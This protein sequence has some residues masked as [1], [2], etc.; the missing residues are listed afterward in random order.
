MRRLTAALLLS[1]LLLAVAGCEAT[2]TAD[3]LSPSVAGP[4]PG[5]NITAPKTVAPSSARVA[6]DQQPLTL[7][8]ENASSNG[9]RPLTYTFELAT[10]AGFTNKVLSR[11]SVSPGSDGRTSLKLPDPLASGRT[12]YWRARAQDGA[13]TGPYS[14]AANFDVFTPTA[15]DQPIPVMPINNVKIENLRPRFMVTNAARSGPVGAISYVFE[16]SDT[17][18]F[19]NKLAIWTVPEQPNQ[20]AF[21]APQ[22]LQYG[23]QYFWHARAFDGATTGSW[24]A[25]QVFQTP[26]VT[27]DAPQ[28]V[29][30]ASGATVDNLH[31]RF[32]WTNASRTGSVGPVSYTLELSESDTFATRLA[33][34]AVGEQPNQTTLDPPQDLSYGK[35]Y[36]WHVRAFSQ[37]A[38][39]P[40]S[41]TLAFQTQTL[42]LAQAQLV[43]PASGVTLDSL[44]PTFLWNNAP[45]SG[46]VGPV[47]YTLELSDT[48]AFANKLAVWA[49]GEQPNQ[50][51][52]VAPQ[53]LAYSKQY[54]W[55][56]RAFSPLATGAWSAAQAFHT[57]EPPPP[58]APP[59]PPGGGGNPPAPCGPPYPNTPL[60][61]VQCQRSNYGQSMSSTDLV[62]LMTAI[63]RDLNAAGVSGGPF[64]ILRK[65]SGSQCNGYS[66][67]IICAGQGNSQQ[68]WDV[69]SDVGNTNRPTWN[70]P[71]TVPN[72]RVDVCEIQ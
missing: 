3:P 68:Q 55:H 59:P 10:D 20:T 61:I 66:C 48:D 32:F 7:V 35:Q 27:I 46:S 14:A 49:V 8:V 19:A 26:S 60:G 25:T 11:D 69:L 17:D 15:I 65:T 23:K 28:L 34:W 9:P 39:G 67:D 13:N 70:G 16:L 2:K 72:I 37:L 45:R 44:H 50:T 40:W 12:Y 56:V 33:V 43:L 51:S 36:F 47:T 63:A 38:I 30:P 41:P 21:D 31:P 4:I 52:L 24:S 62:N 42:T 57:P 29:F 53:D 22:D 18:T 1:P 54:F 58:P 6:V 64:G 5:V 71:A